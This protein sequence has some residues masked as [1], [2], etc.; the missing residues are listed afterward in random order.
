MSHD[1]MFDRGPTVATDNDGQA[2]WSIGVLVVPKVDATQTEG[3]FSLIE[4]TAPAGWETPYH[5]HHGEDE[6]FYVLEG[7]IDCYY[8]EDGAEMLH[9]EANDTVFLPRDI[10]HGFRVVSDEQCRMLI[11]LTPAGFEGFF[12]EA[13][14]P[15]ERRETPPPAEPDPEA[16]AEI[17][18]KYQLDILGPLPA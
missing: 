4:H 15:A 8:G 18:R 17:G 13:G 3:A 11:Q 6:L 1:T 10:P 7:A 16:L 2:L 9:A 14:V 5:V 12:E